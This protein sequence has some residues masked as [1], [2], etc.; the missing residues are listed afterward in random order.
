MKILVLNGVNLDMLGKREANIYG[1]ESLDDL[2]KRIDSL[3]LDADIEYFQSNSEEEII[4][5]IHSHAQEEYSCG[6]FNFGAH[7]HT[8]VAIRDAILAVEFPFYEVHISNVYSREEFRHVS[9]FSDIAIGCIVG[10]GF[11]GYEFALQKILR[12]KNGS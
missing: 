2:Y 8:N 9:F 5:K 12:S 7:T 10:F 4:K 11:D 3:G 1:S 6:V